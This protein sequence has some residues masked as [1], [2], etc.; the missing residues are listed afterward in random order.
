MRKLCSMFAL[1]IATAITFISCAGLTFRYDKDAKLKETLLSTVPD[2][3]ATTFLVFSDAHLYDTSLGT[4][5]K[6]FQE[7]LANDRKLLIESEEILDE[8]IARMTAL[9]ADFVIV[10]GDLTKDG[11]K[12]C[13]DLFVKKIAKLEEAG[14]QVFVVPGNHDVLN[15]HAV[16]FFSDGKKQV[17][18]YD[19][20]EFAEVYAAFGYN[21]AIARDPSSLSYVVEPVEGLWV[22]ALD[23]CDYS[24]NIAD[25]YPKTDGAFSASQR[26]WIEEMLIKAHNEKKATMAFFH[27]GILQHYGTQEKYYGEYVVDGYEEISEMLAMYNVRMVFT[28]HYHAQDITMHTMKNGKFILDIETGSLV[29]Y[30]CPFRHVTI[31]ASQEVAI[32]SAFIDT[33]ASIPEG[34]RDHAKQYVYDGIAGIAID[35]M[36]GYNATREEAEYIAPQV[37]RAFIAHYEG[38]ERLP[39]GQTMIDKKGVTSFMGKMIVNNRKALVEGLWKDIPPAD[40][41][42][43]VNLRTG[44]WKELAGDA[45]R[46]PEDRTPP[47]SSTG[48][49]ERET[50]GA[51]DE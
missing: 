16:S 40:N 20:K 38:D 7:Y 35:T 32:R 34:F 18:Y 43:R 25:D 48:E 2:Y 8:A 44:T 30:P 4:E 17:A 33:I 42:I 5:G 47:A 10:P 51:E 9:D 45:A 50:D 31:D 46:V 23:S 15:T 11:E 1:A 36:L 41:A 39:E 27:H 6:A 13:H 49:A 26:A 29:T 14:M 37:A 28:G 24:N 12:A 22:F 19:D 21:E 3:P